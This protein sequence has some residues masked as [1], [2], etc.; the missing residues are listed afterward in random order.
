MKNSEITH[1]HTQSI[2]TSSEWQKG[3]FV[4]KYF[5][6]KKCQLLRSDISI[7]RSVK[8]KLGSALAVGLI[9]AKNKMTKVT[10]CS[11]KSKK[12]KK[13]IEVSVK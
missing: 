8:L 3:I 4:L 9:L 10:K 7:R 2:N 5:C 6:V 13:R 12:K 11:A 1:A